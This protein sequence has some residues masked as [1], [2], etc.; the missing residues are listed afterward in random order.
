MFFM[1][2]LWSEKLQ[3]FYIG[4]TQDLDDRL[5]YH[6]AGFVKFTSLGTPWVL[7]YSEGFL[8]RADATKR[9]REI[10]AWKSAVAI[11]ALIRNRTT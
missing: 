10:K 11:R 1:Y 8:T 4:S 9:E 7:V 5:I 3:K 6:N 2:I